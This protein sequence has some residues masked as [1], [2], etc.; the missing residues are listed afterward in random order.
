M[1]NLKLIIYSRFELLRR[2]AL[3]DIMR[4]LVMKKAF[5]GIYHIR[6]IPTLVEWLPN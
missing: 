5:K 6:K 2:A 3:R 4:R 1:Q